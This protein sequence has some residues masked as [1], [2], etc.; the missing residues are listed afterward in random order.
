MLFNFQG[1]FRTVSFQ[2][3]ELDF[4]TS[5][6]DCQELFSRPPPLSQ[7]ATF[8]SYHTQLCLSRTFFRSWHFV[9]RLWRQDV[10]LSHPLALVK[11]FLR[12]FSRSFNLYSFY[13]RRRWQLL[14][15]IAFG[16]ESQ[17]FFAK[18]I[19]FF[20]INFMVYFLAALA[21]HLN[22]LICLYIYLIIYIIYIS[23]LYLIYMCP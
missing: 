18:Y 22:S 12:F 5:L 3:V 7:A 16:T 6:C 2:T 14:Y 9:V 10:I 23:S 11:D 13:R 4:I 21:G 17:H 19:T 20:S 8:I 1:A 15:N